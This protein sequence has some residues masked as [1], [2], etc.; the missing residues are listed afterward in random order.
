MIKSKKLL[1]AFCFIIV[2]TTIFYFSNT[3][4]IIAKNEMIDI[5]VDIE[6]TNALANKYDNS[7]E[8]YVNN[9]YLICKNYKITK[10]MFDDSL[11]YYN[12]NPRELYSVYA[13]VKSKLSSLL[14]KQ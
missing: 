5:L 10:K 4:K 2:A 13:K 7:D 12:N 8:F 3:K 11:F 1:L 6:L 14:I 9:F